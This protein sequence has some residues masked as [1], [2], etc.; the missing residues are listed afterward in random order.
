[1]SSRS[2][3][4]ILAAGFL[5]CAVLAQE[6]VTFSSN[7][8]G[9][10]GGSN[11]YVFDRVD[12]AASQ[13]DLL[14]A[15]CEAAGDWI[16]SPGSV[17]PAPNS[18]FGGFW[19]PVGPG[20]RKLNCGYLNRD[21]GQ[22]ISGTITA[23]S[24]GTV[25]TTNSNKVGDPISTVTGE[26][27]NDSLPPDLALGGPLP[28]EFRRYYASLIN[29]NGVTTR[30]G[31][32]WAHSFEWQLLLFGPYAAVTSPEQKSFLFIQSGNTWSLF[33]QEDYGY[34]FAS[35]GNN[36]YQFLDPRTN[37]I[38]TFS[39][40]SSTL[41]NTSILDRNGNTLSITL[42]SNGSAQASDGLGRTLTITYDTNNKLI[43]VSDQSGRF[44]SY[45]Y[46]GDDLTQFTD[47]NGK[48][49]Q[50]SATTSGVFKGL[51][52]STTLPL[53]NKPTTQTF[54][55]FGRVLTQT[56]SRGNV[57]TL[58][59]DQPVNTTS[60]K[61]PLGAVITDTSRL[62]M[63]FLSRADPDNQTISTT[64]DA[65]GRRNS[66]TDRLGDKL[67]ITYH[68]PSG[69][70]ASITDVQGNTT[71]N[72]YISQTSGPFT[73]YLPSKTQYSDGTSSS[74]VYDSNGNRISVTDQAGKSWTTSYN[75][76]GQVTGRFDP[77]GRGNTY[78]YN[79]S[80]ATLATS[81]DPAGNVT[82]YSYDSL[83][84]VNQIKFADGT[85]RSFTYDALDNVLK[86][87]NERG[88]TTS[89][90]YNDNNNLQTTTDAFGKSATIAYDTDDHVNK[91]TDR[92]GLSATFAYNELG[93]LKSTT[94]PAGE[95][96]TET[97][98]THHRE[99]AALDPVG[100]GPGFAYT[101][102]DAVASITDALSRK[103]SIATDKFNLVSSVTIPSGAMYS[104][105]RDKFEHPLL[106]TD[107]ANVVTSIAYDPRGLMNSLAVGNGAFNLQSGIVHDE[108][109]LVTA[110]TDPN[111]NIWSFGYDPAGRLT[112]RTDPLKRPT[113]YSFDL[114]NRVSNVT[115]PLGTG[116]FSYDLTGNL[117]RRH[118]SDGTDLN[119]TYDD[120]NRM[121]SAPG[122]TLAYDAE[123]RVTNSNGLQIAHD[124]NG[125][126]SSITYAVGKSVR[127]AYNSVGLLAAVTDWLT[128]SITFTYDAAHQLTSISRPNSRG[129][130]FTYD[131]DGRVASIN[132]DAGAAIAIKRDAAGKTVSDSR[133]LPAN[134]P[135]S[136]S[137]ANGVLP[138]SYDAADQIG[139]FSY[140]PLGR[141]ATENLRRYTWDLASELASYSGADGSAVATYDG[142][143][144]RT[145]VNSPSGNRAFIWNYATAL[146][147]LAT[148]Q[149]D[150]GD[151]RYYIY[152]PD[153]ALLYAV[154]AATGA[155][156]FYHFDENGSTMLLTSDFGTVTDSYAISPYGETVTQG[157]S[158]ENP[159]TWMGRYGVMQE[160][161]T[162]LYYM[163]ARY[164]D[165][166]TARF[167]SPDPVV[168]AHPLGSNPY[169]YA[170]ANPLEFADPTGLDPGDP[171]IRYDQVLGRFIVTESGGPNSSFT[172]VISPL[173][174]PRFINNPAPQPLTNTQICRTVL[175]YPFVTN[176][177]GFDIGLG[178]PN[179]TTDPFGT[180]PQPGSCS[181]SFYGSSAPAQSQGS[182][183][184]AASSFPFA[185]GGGGCGAGFQGYTI[186]FC[187]FQYAH[188]FAFVS[189]LAAPSLS[190]GYL[191]GILPFIRIAPPKPDRVAR[192]EVLAH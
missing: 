15:I 131:A 35:L 128:G 91:I 180:R 79:A 46:T 47:A 70:I 54:D 2:L 20:G 43:R 36:T 30:I 143:G 159:F 102:E 107:P 52:T 152:T 73:F 26:L 51:I 104:V 168:S 13:G 22:L 124:P 179:T 178:I 146:P 100:K 176:T 61:D 120:S 37:L 65:N 53:G 94:T 60:F 63:E 126:I 17:N 83:K 154:D 16:G 106:A 186:A 138:L 7:F 189:D 31:N 105:T 139:Q 19:G 162:G 114:R 177:N 25:A 89:F 75:S 118:Y 42:P 66:V 155:R 136:P 147:S 28:L 99:S 14:T 166:V 72:T 69:Y 142:L 190:Q 192:G 50:Y 97:Y 133:T 90:A 140:D 29:A 81:T 113:T 57:T 183:S 151:R 93:L 76:R 137:L 141:I 41:G 82:N 10:W 157:G 4:I 62:Y 149:D 101:K 92:L 130:Q 119:Y 122:L 45:G 191:N 129:T 3:R 21:S 164:Y 121:T 153:G 98:D 188:R 111:N 185:T 56:D 95:T 110:L 27:Y 33:R 116:T 171:I 165:S 39:G 172:K 18:F 71:T 38:Y 74:Y 88:K 123:D 49:T 84:R 109:G 85:S 78:T 158:T 144:Q 132:E 96:F 6:K 175:L 58:T 148:V 12:L 87:V 67:S 156:H 145:S 184:S 77:N 163:R 5:S 9:T 127:Y 115:T 1:M 170:L 108:S 11:L 181:L 161:A 59:Y 44:V 112:S 24:P 64:Y 86:I 173:Y 150:A 68:S 134:A 182:I 187:N 160:G 117:L 40:T 125:R 8:F 135:V 169:Q 34:Q 167:I 32:N 55:T 103:S 23:L 48:I 80:D 174:V